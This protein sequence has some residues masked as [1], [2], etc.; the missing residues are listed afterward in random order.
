MV[1]FNPLAILGAKSGPVAIMNTLYNF[2]AGDFFVNYP[3]VTLPPCHMLE[4]PL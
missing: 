3:V 2:N 1:C 4:M